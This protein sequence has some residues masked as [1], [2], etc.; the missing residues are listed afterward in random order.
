LVTVF[1]FLFL[2]LVLTPSLPFVLVL[3]LVLVLDPCFA[4][5]VWISSPTTKRCPSNLAL[6]NV[7]PVLGDHVP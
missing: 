7:Y 5:P 4:L 3:V 1:L 6:P 2:F